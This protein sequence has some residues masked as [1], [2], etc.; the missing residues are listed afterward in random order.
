MR[1]HATTLVIFAIG[2]ALIFF[3]IIAGFIPLV[4]GFVFII[5]GFYII[6][7]RSKWL[8]RL[9]DWIR[10]K[11]RRFDQVISSFDRASDFVV[12]RFRQAIAILRN[13]FGDMSQL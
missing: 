12:S 9:T 4:P 10:R 13:L 7:R 6:S 2:W 5:I 8:T 11:N 1:R 3:G